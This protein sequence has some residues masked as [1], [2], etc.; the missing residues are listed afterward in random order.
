MNSNTVLNQL[1]VE[2]EH[3]HADL[4]EA[5]KAI[6]TLDGTLA[7]LEQVFI[8]LIHEHPDMRTPIKEYLSRCHTNVDDRVM[9]DSVRRLQALLDVRKQAPRYMIRPLTEIKNTADDGPT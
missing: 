9:K 5:I 8:V 6:R 4:D 2:V 3:L 1:Q 7:V